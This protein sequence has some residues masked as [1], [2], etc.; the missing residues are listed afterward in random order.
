MLGPERQRGNRG[1][2]REFR[3]ARVLAV[4]KAEVLESA[5]NH[6]PGRFGE[7]QW[8]LCSVSERQPLCAHTLAFGLPEP[9]LEAQRKG[10][11]ATKGC[12]VSRAGDGSRSR[13]S[14][15]ME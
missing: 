11:A 2:S 10:K 4:E 5:G 13:P 15:A 12:S 7:G 8:G 3:P 9:L 14:S 1:W 6:S